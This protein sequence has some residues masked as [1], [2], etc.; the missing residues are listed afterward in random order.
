MKLLPA[1]VLVLV[2][3]TA[4]LAQQAPTGTFEE[5]TK[6]F[7]QSAARKALYLRALAAERY[8]ATGEHRALDL[9]LK[10]YVR[11]EPPQDHV[12]YLLAGIAGDAFVLEEHVAK[13]DEVARQATTAPDAWLWFQTLRLK[14]RYQ[15]ADAAVA[16][17]VDGARDPFLR[18]AA[19]EVLAQDPAAAEVVLS[20]IPRVLGPDAAKLRPG[21]RAVLLEACAWTLPAARGHAG[22]EPF[23][24]AATLVIDALDDKK[25]EARTKLVVARALAGALD[26]KALFLDAESW[27]RVLRGK[28]EA[29]TEDPHATRVRGAGKGV[30]TPRFFGVEG[31]GLRIVFVVDLSDSMMAPLKRE[32]VE[33]VRRPRTG[34]DPTTTTT[35]GKKPDEAPPSTDE[36]DLP[37]EKIKTRFDVARESLRRSLAT[38]G[39]GLSFAV[40]VFGTKAELLGG[41]G[42]GKATPQNVQRAIAA[43]DAIRPGKAEPGREAGTLRGYTN[44]HGGLRLAFRLTEGPTIPAHEHV[45]PTGFESG[46]DTIFLLSDGAPSWDDFDAEDIATM[47][48]GDPETGAPLGDSERLHYYGPYVEWRFLLRDVERMNLFRRVELHCIGIGEATPELLRSLSV[49]GRGELRIIGTAR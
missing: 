10:R 34:S 43:L 41:T 45:A 25:L 8:A 2:T 31:A 29:S 19:L 49:L 24:A 30:T 32:E 17:A 48:A 12:R 42:L 46:C 5:E 20:T 16:V 38:L 6:A 44:L 28:A 1:G 21:Q 15:G 22:S 13:F 26:S 39:P 14:S 11:A 27:R 18:A 4:A 36:Q 7:Q 35:R 37:W 9:L 47:K 3:A 40:V 33:E 23:A